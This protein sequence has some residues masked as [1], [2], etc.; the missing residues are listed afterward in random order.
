MTRQLT[1]FFLHPHRLIVILAF[2][3]WGLACAPAPTADAPSILR[4]EVA[5]SIYGL[6]YDPGRDKI[7][8]AEAGPQARTEPSRILQ[9]DPHTLRVENTLAV[10]E[11]VFDVVLSEDGSRLYAVHSTDHAFSV[12]DL[13]SREVTHTVR[14]TRERPPEEEAATIVL[15]K[16]VPDERNQR[17][18]LAETTWPQ[19]A[20]Y[21]VNANTLEVET[22]VPGIGLFA[23]GMALD[24]AG[25]RLFIANMDHDII[26]LDTRSLEI[27]QR[28]KVNVDQPLSLAY[29]SPRDRLYVSDQGREYWTEFMAGHAPHYQPLGTGNKVLVVNAADGTPVREIATAAGPLELVVSEDGKRLYVTQRE[30]GSV[31][32][33][34]TKTGQLIQRYA[35]PIH[36]NSVVLDA[37]GR[38]LFVTIKD[39]MENET[40]PESVAR[41]N[42]P[43]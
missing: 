16:L 30:D 22:I 20:L 2:C 39:R 40:L 13:D 8:V 17:L 5:A 33:H 36:P 19:G 14:L 32:V 7:Y 43:D 12:V 24:A 23:M 25:Q 18:F 1:P 41:I 9:L 4:Q 42:L 34:D 29:D 28:W 38:R 6:T 37:Q 27:V 31:A 35:L 15:R 26:V 11:T 10:P 3:M 21:V